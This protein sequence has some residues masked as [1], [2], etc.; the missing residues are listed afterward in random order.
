[1]QSRGSQALDTLIKTAADK[2]LRNMRE[3]KERR[4][5]RKCLNIQTWEKND[6]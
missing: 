3:V 4:E 5:R 1:M 6:G 2:A